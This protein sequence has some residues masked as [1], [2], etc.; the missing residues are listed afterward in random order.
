MTMF[1]P[2]P[3]NRYSIIYA[4]PPWDY[5]GQRQYN[6][7]GVD[8]GGAELHYPTIPLT[9]LRQLPITD[10]AAADC[11]LFLWTTNPH[12]PQALQLAADWGFQYC[13]IAFVWDKQAVVPGYYTMSQYEHCLVFKRGRI[14]QPRGARNIRQQVIAPRGKHSVKPAIVR[15]RIDEMFPHQRK[16]EL[17][18]R[19]PVNSRLWDTWGNE[20]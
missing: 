7:S 1:P 13:T 2:L 17:F 19:A 9:T 14:P 10:V 6:A 5:R 3:S 16:L 15:Q 20:P 11:L 8:T 4:D 12:L 18:A